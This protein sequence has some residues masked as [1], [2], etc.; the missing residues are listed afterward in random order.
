[1]RAQI[2]ASVLVELS[3]A[4][5]V[6]LFALWG[7]HLALAQLHAVGASAANSA[8]A[9]AAAINSSIEPYRIFGIAK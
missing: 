8:N 2:S 9:S 6:A 3:M 1:V 4:L 5:A 7:M